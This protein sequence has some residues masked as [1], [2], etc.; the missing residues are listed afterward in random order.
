MI[1]IKSANICGQENNSNL[2][3]RLFNLVMFFEFD[4]F[5]SFYFSILFY[6]MYYSNKNLG[7][8]L[9][10]LSNVFSWLPRWTP[11]PTWCPPPRRSSICPGRRKTPRA[12]IFESKIVTGYVFDNTNLSIKTSERNVSLFILFIACTH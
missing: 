3:Q 12:Q 10:K 7:V 6:F 2:K 4:N 11:P 9:M 8:S 5:L 1:S